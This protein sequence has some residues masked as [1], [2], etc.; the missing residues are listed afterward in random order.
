[1]Q[2]MAQEVLVNVALGVLTLLSS[3]ALYYIRKATAKVT[4]EADKIKNDDQR[5]LAQA[6]VERLND[7]ATKTVTAIEQTTASEL[8]LAVKNGQATK[9]DL[10]RLSKQAYG[11]IVQT[12]QPDY[13]L[14]LQNTLGDLDTYIKSTIEAKVLELKKSSAIS[15]ALELREGV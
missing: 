6:A 3:Y 14:A 15:Q 12:M 11:E 4:A 5:A 2:D 1:M 8:R 10:V 9:D 7:I 13:L